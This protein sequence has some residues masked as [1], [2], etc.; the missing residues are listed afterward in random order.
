MTDKLVAAL[1]FLVLA[2]GLVF[3]GYKWWKRD[4]TVHH[5]VSPLT[6]AACPP[7]TPMLGDDF[8]WTTEKVMSMGKQYRNC[9]EA[10]LAK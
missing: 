6:I 9:R 8:G 10:C 4:V 2:A 3:V 5:E 1:L 7:P